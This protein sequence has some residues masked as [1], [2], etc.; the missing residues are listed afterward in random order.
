[1][2]K[3][4]KAQTQKQLKLL[5]GWKVKN[6]KKLTK[7]FIFK[8]F[9]INMSFLNKVAKV[10]E[11]LG[12]HPDFKVKYNQVEFEIWT[13]SAGGI[14]NK[15]FELALKIEKTVKTLFS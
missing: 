3:L 12:H 15:D 1:M 6:G 7:R 2:N 14:T 9:V 11:Q 8:N 10:A 5:S 4:N 13:H